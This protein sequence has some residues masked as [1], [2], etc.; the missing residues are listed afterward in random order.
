M[1]WLERRTGNAVV[2]QVG[3]LNPQARTPEAHSPTVY[4]YLRLYEVTRKGHLRRVWHFRTARAE[5]RR[6]A[7]KS[8]RSREMWTLARGAGRGPPPRIPKLHS[9]GRVVLCPGFRRLSLTEKGP[10]SPVPARRGC[11]LRDRLAGIVPPR[12]T[13]YRPPRAHVPAADGT[14]L[15][16]P[17]VSLSGRIVGANHELGTGSEPVS[18]SG[19]SPRPLLHDGVHGTR[20]R[21]LREVCETPPPS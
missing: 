9:R 13:Q 1:D 11:C 20:P 16:I 2:S 21:C 6:P 15:S 18:V 5:Y 19:A 3:L 10:R 14:P 12:D 8:L 17:P 4:H 7:R